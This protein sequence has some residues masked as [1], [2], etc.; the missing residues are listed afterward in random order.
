MRRSLAAV[1]ILAW[2]FI[3]SESAWAQNSLEKNRK[4][5]FP[6]ERVSVLPVVFTP[7]GE[8]APRKELDGVSAAFEMD[9]ATLRGTAGNDV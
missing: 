6:P 5:Y 9:T 3:C 2:A 7:K 1:S 8:K 4:H